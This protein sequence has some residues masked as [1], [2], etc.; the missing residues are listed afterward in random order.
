MQTQMQ[1]TSALREGE[2]PTPACL[3]RQSI[4]RTL[5]GKRAP[6]EP[7][8]SLSLTNDVFLQSY[9]WARWQLGIPLPS[10]EW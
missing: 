5:P 9:N 7:V 1:K 4:H 3:T 8:V 2:V 10:A 6:D